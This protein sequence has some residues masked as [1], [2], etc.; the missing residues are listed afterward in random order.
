[1]ILFNESLFCRINNTAAVS[2]LGPRDA[3]SGVTW[4]ARGAKSLTLV[5][6]GGIGRIIS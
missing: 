1:M 4:H 3:I 2:R 6:G 5:S